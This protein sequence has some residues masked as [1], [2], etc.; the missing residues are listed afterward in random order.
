MVSIFVFHE[1]DMF[2]IHLDSFQASSRDGSG[3]SVSVYKAELPE[4]FETRNNLVTECFLIERAMHVPEKS[5]HTEN[6]LTTSTE[7]SKFQGMWRVRVWQRQQ[8][9]SRYVLPPPSSMYTSQY[10]VTS[11]II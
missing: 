9:F 8:P 6:G 2:E 11:N 10:R 3:R 5:K 1:R 4:D 7:F